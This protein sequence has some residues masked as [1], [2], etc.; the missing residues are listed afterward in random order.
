MPEVEYFFIISKARGPGNAALVLSASSS[1]GADVVVATLDYQDEKQMWEKRLRRADDTAVFALVNKARG[2]CLARAS[3]DNGAA[4]VLVPVGRIPSDDLAVWQHDHV[5]G[6]YNALVSVQEWEQK[7]NIFGDGPYTSGSRTVSWHWDGGSD[8]ELW[9][10]F[11]SNRQI[12]LKRIEFMLDASQL[13][14]QPPTVLYNTRIVNNSDQ[15]QEQLFEY[16]TSSTKTETY[17]ASAGLELSAQYEIQVGAPLAVSS[18]VT[19]GA[20]VTTTITFGRSHE[21]SEEIKVS[22][23]V[24]VPPRSAVQ[25]NILVQSSTIDVPFRAVYDVTYEDGVTQE[26]IKNGTYNQIAFYNAHYTITQ[27]TPN[28]V[29]QPADGT[30]KLINQHGKALDVNGGARAAGT[31][32]I[33]WPYGNGANQRWLLS[34]VGGGCFKL[35]AEHSG[36]VLDVSGGSLADGAPL[37]QW[38][39][40]G[41]G[42]QLWQLIAN[43]DGTCRLQSK[44]SGK[45]LDVQD[46]GSTNGT[47]LVQRAWN[48]SPG[49]RWSVTRL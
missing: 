34:Y 17:S 11:S 18:K 33:Q 26:V 32:I 4:L 9:R 27:E 8:N 1:G 31:T 47:P 7:V 23:P 36:L 29:T 24:K 38:Q 45:V 3:A 28:Q 40:F 48:G 16:T 25:A 19:L 13:V 2:T 22:A 42:N 12:K 49:Q 21:T 14:E 10:F 15:E 39:W 46:G 6:Q 30:Y 20:K 5:E 37:I 44:N 41:S 35:T 43:G